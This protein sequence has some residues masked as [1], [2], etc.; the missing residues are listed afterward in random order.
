MAIPRKRAPLAPL[1]KRNKEKKLALGGL[2]LSAMGA[3][4]ILS[5][6]V[7]VPAVDRAKMKLK[8]G[9]VAS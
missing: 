9:A 8:T 4:V 6:N 7:G 2:L 1:L 5:G 3:T